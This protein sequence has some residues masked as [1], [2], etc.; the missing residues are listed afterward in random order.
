MK[1]KA[2]YIVD[3][4]LAGAM[5]WAID[6]DDFSGTHCHEGNFPLTNTVKK[7]FSENKYPARTK[8]SNTTKDQQNVIDYQNINEKLEKEFSLLMDSSIYQKNSFQIPTTTYQAYTQAPFKIPIRIPTATA[9]ST[10]I[11]IQN[12]PQKLVSDLV[13]DNKKISEFELADPAM[14]NFR[15]SD[16]QIHNLKASI[17]RKMTRLLKSKENGFRDDFVCQADGNF[18]DKTSGC[19]VFY[20]CLWVNTPWSKKFKNICPEKTIFNSKYQICDWEDKVVCE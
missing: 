12:T 16:L 8:E 1:I 20:N 7:Y 5:F 4:D 10:S 15:Q 9:M 6:I 11:L 17:I 3:N 18:A 14:K 13:V 19:I 2:K